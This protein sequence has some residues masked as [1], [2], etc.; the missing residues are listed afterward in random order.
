MK[1]LIE[2]ITYQKAAKNGR[3]ELEC[4]SQIQPGFAYE[5]R[6]AVALVAAVVSRIAHRLFTNMKPRDGQPRD[7][8]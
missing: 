6:L 8:W 3:R 1:V 4:H 2:K 5:L 7:S